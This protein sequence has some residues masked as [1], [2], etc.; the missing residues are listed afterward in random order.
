MNKSKRVTVRLTER[1]HADL[2]RIAQRERQATGF[3]VSVSDIMR[4][5]VADYLKAKGEQDA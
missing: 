2:E 5:A 1:E 4:A 3:T